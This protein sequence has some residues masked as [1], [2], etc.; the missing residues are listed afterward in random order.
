MGG[1]TMRTG[2]LTKHPCVHGIQREGI[3][4]K[5]NP[6]QRQRYPV[7]LCVQ[8]FIPQT[9]PSQQ[10][11]HT[12]VRNRHDYHYTCINKSQNYQRLICFLYLC[13]FMYNFFFSK[14]VVIVWD[15][16][17]EDDMV[18]TSSGIGDDSHR[19]PV[20]KVTW[21]PDTSSMKKNKYLV[22]N[23]LCNFS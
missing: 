12:Q 11:V 8:P 23:V 19:E 5:T 15:L 10:G 3:W 4:M 18:L 14:G 16:S 21:V 20:S 9:L 7:V 2:V 1:M 17:R 6:T 13:G 22:W